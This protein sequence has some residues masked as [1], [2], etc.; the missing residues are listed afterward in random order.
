MPA[1]L[2]CERLFCF[3]SS[4][5]DLVLFVLMWLQTKIEIETCYKIKRMCAFDGKL[6]KC[7]SLFL[8]VGNNSFR[9]LVW[10]TS[11]KPT[12]S[13]IMFIVRVSFLNLLQG[14]T[15]Y[16]FARFAFAHIQSKWQIINSSA[17]DKNQFH[18]K[19]RNS[20]S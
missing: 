12:H 15:F 3:F 13:L 1:A 4:V 5:P 17:N 18:F 2:M 9:K 16:Q 8:L 6:G 14:T 7:D 20:T 11:R 19:C 10:Y